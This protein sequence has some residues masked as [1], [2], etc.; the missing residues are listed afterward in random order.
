MKASKT[1]LGLSAKFNLLSILLVVCTAISVVSFQIEREWTRHITTM[2]ANGSQKSEMIAQFS[3]YA[4]YT[5]DEESLANIMAGGVDIDTTYLGLLR[6]DKTVLAE[7]SQSP[8]GELFPEWRTQNVALGDKPSFTDD[9][10]HVQ[11][12]VPILSAELS[13]LDA[14]IAENE[15]ENAGSRTIGYVRY[16]SNTERMQAGTKEAFQSVIGMAT[17]IV[18]V[19]IV[20][21]LYL[22][23]RIV[24]PVSQLVLATRQIADGHMEEN[25]EISSGGE[26]SHLASNFN[27]M[28]QQL[29]ASRQELKAHQQ[30]LE[31]RVEERTAELVEAKEAAEAGSRAKSEFLATMSHEIRTPMNGVLGMTELLLSSGL[32]KRQRHLATSAHRS[33]DGLLSVIN[34]ILDFSKIEADKLEIDQ[35]D[36]DL[37]EVCEDTLEMVAESAQ[38]KGLELVSDLA[39]DTPMVVGDPTRVRQVLLNLI[40]NAIKFTDTGEVRLSQRGIPNSD[41]GLEVAF[42]ILDTGVGIDS[43]KLATIFDAFTQADGSTSRSYG[44]TGLGLAIVR[45]L[46]ESHE[47]KV[48]VDTAIDHHTTFTFTLPIPK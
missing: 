19:A 8:V 4:V 20:L 32:D 46:I 47:G 28:L 3:E 33:A 2:L 23:R 21:T 29:R 48:A 36:F 18:I 35:Q 10:K 6:N 39:N 43:G 7:S 1:R 22:T 5:E 13:T 37:L 9:E 45:Q 24:G 26:L 44:G 11:F 15:A 17:I 34:D 40:S 42:E 16:I 25:V 12:I 31:H 14:F 30:T 27:H 41:N 38:R